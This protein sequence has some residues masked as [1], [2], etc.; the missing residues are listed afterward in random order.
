MKEN[1]PEFKEKLEEHGMI[2]IHVLAQ[3]DDALS[4]SGQGWKSSFIPKDK[5]VT[6]E[7]TAKFD[8]KGPE[9]PLVT[10]QSRRPF[11]PPS[12]VLASLRK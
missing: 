2:Y 5:S 10:C 9:N 12:C 4:P 3:E 11:N 8:K 6:V 1:H 7:R